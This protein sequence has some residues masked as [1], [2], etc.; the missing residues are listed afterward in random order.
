MTINTYPIKI[1]QR[2]QLTIPQS[3]R[4]KWSTQSG[5]VI[6]LVQFDEF[7]ILAP[8]TLKTPSLARQFS[9]IMD[10]EGVSLADLLEGLQEE[11]KKL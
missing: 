11:T 4:E 10:E 1:R 9:Q 3:V 2:G 7:A 8:T 5:D 6:T